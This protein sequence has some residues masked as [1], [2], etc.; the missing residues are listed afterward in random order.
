LTLAARHRWCVLCVLVSLMP[1]SELLRP[2]IARADGDPASDVLLTENVY[3]P[4]S[5]P[6]A[7]SLASILATTVRHAHAAGFPIKVALIQSPQDLGAVP[8]LF[9]TPQRYAKFL[10]LEISYNSQAKL[11]VV[12]PQGFGTAGVGSSTSLSG[13][14]VD[15][16]QRSDGLARAAVEAV[17]ALARGEGHPIPTPALPHADTGGG[18]SP[19]PFVVVGAGLIVL[20]GAG[21]STLRGRTPR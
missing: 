5:S 18:A 3:L 1:A 20:V 4:Y 15:G 19:W 8:R 2:A 10:D 14:H 21:V 6:V 7:P 16:K 9:G 12:M 17:A 11:L 13:I